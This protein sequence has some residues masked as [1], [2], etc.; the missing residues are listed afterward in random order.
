MSANHR[1]QLSLL[2]IPS[3]QPYQAQP[4]FPL[5]SPAL[6][7][8]IHQGFPPAFP[9]P[10]LL[11]TPVQPSF[12]PPP[13]GA[14][15]RSLHQGHRAQTSVSL[16]AAGIHP[17]PGIPVTPLQQTQFPPAF[18]G[19][20]FPPFQHRNRRQPSI[21]TGGPP[22]AQL[23]GVG[24][25]YRPPSPTAVAL[26]NVAAQNQK[27]KKTIVNLPKETTPAIDEKPSERAHFARTP[28]PL[29]LIP[30]QPSPSP[31]DVISAVI[32]PE[33]SLRTSIPDTVDVFLPAKVCCSSAAV[34][35]S[36]FFCQPAWEVLK[37]KFIEEKL[38]K[39][40]VEKGS[41]SSSTV[42]HIHAPHARA[43]SV[44]RFLSPL[45]FRSLFRRYLPLQILL[46]YS[47]S[48]TNSNRYK[49]LRHTLRP[50][51]HNCP[52]ILLITRRLP[53]Q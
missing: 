26:V 4:H 37:K 38:E 42:P 36:N 34:C 30:P 18:G 3:G 31:P 17:P 9:P 24:K 44:R 7:T 49:F 8:A 52:N 43:A 23:G 11:Q 5:Y 12:F 39:L 25:N 35:I 32:H 33:D 14:P 16:A 41:G 2:S 27:V 28:L 51:R 1:Q 50:F 29:H 46:Y 20:Q 21:S 45:W 22:K 19:P 47:L 13:S 48:S 10:S 53:L 6:P 40:G 15:H